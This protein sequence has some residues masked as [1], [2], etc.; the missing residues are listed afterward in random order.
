MEQS[1]RTI[2]RNA[3]ICKRMSRNNSHVRMKVYSLGITLKIVI[4]DNGDILLQQEQVTA[5]RKTENT[6]PEETLH[7]PLAYATML[8]T[9]YLLQLLETDFKSLDLSNFHNHSLNE[10]P[11]GQSYRKYFNIKTAKLFNI[12]KLESVATSKTPNTQL[13]PFVDTLIYIL[14]HNRN[15]LANV[16]NKIPNE[17][18]ELQR[19]YYIAKIDKMI[20]ALSDY[21]YDIK[22]LHNIQFETVQKNIELE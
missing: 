18:L 17:L 13:K 1:L 21:T 20:E 7:T 2:I 12:Q 15:L 16:Y 11:D 10:T 3:E 6:I 4:K 5:K 8:N 9:S 22:S 14:E 19:V